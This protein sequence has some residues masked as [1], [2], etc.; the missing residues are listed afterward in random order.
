VSFALSI[1]P[2]KG[3]LAKAEEDIK[4]NKRINSKEK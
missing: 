4:R 1:S 2:F 3:K